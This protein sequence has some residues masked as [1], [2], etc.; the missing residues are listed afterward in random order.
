[1]FAASR[2]V[3]YIRYL[4]KVRDGSVRRIYSDHC[5][6]CIYVQIIADEDGNSIHFQLEMIEAGTFTWMIRKRINA[7]QEWFDDNNDDESGDF[8]DNYRH[9]FLFAITRVPR[10]GYTAQPMM[11]QWT[12]RHGR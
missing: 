5:L 4:L 9:Y 7:H 10:S 6:T 2:T 11:L 12:L 1:M 3:R 8:E